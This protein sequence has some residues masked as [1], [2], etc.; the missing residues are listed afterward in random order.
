VKGIGAKRYERLK[1][2]ITVTPMR[3][4]AAAKP[5]AAGPAVKGDIKA[6][7]VDKPHK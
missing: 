1:S 2:E 5:A 7:A 6:T 4:A 3:T